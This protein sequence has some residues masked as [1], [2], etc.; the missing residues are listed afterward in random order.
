MRRT[1]PSATHQ[2]T[3]TVRTSVN[4]QTKSTKNYENEEREKVNEI[5]SVTLTKWQEAI[6]KN[7]NTIPTTKISANKF[8]CILV[9]FDH[10]HVYFTAFLFGFKNLNNL[11]QNYLQLLDAKLVSRWPPIENWASTKCWLY[12]YVR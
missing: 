7:L 12:T 9:D 5:W 11:L 2:A 4:S 8:T 6:C 3:N 1:H 10:F